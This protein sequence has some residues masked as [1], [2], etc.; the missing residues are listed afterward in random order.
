MGQNNYYASG[1]WN[2]ICDLC[3]RPGKSGNAVKTWN[4]LWVCAHHKEAR[5][6]QDF[7]RGV[8]DNQSVPWSRSQTEPIFV[9]SV[10]LTQEN[11]CLILQETGNWA[12]AT[13]GPYPYSLN[14][15]FYSV[16]Q[17]DGHLLLQEDGVSELLQETEPLPVND[18][19]CQLP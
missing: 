17:E 18:I 14:Q 19:Y 5:N 16:V 8:K 12:L 2:F 1:Q 15:L 9:G 3:G 6:P 13:E 7:L 11:G 4:N 10:L